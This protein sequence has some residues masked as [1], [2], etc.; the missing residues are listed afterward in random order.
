VTEK[1]KPTKEPFC[2]WGTWVGGM[3]ATDDWYLIVG[4]TEKVKPTKG[5]FCGWGTWVGCISAV[6]NLYQLPNTTIQNTEQSVRYRPLL[7][8]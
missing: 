4:V 6:S 7:F 2:G 5:S 1:V 8:L 3:G